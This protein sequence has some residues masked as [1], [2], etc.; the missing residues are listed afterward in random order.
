MNYIVTRLAH[1]IVAIAL[2]SIAACAS[3]TDL[4]A[5]GRISSQSDAASPSDAVATMDANPATLDANATADDA[6]TAFD[7]ATA[8]ADGRIVQ[9]DAPAMTADAQSAPID[10]S[11]AA[12]AN[13]MTS[14][15]SPTAS[16]ARVLTADANNAAHDAATTTSDAAIV[17]IDARVDH[18][19]VA[20]A[21]QV[22]LDEDTTTDVTVSATDVDGDSLIYAII[23]EPAH[24]SLSGILP[25]LTYTPASNYRGADSFTFKANDG[26]L[27][28]N[29]ATVSITVNPVNHA[30]VA[31]VQSVTTNENTAT[32]VTLS[33]TDVDGDSLTYAVVGSPSHG[34]LSGSAPNLTYTPTSNYHGADSFTFKANDGSLDSNTATV[35]ITVN[36]VDQAPVASTQSVNTEEN[37][38]ADVTMSA[39]DAD[40]DPLTYS[41]VSAP[42]HGELSGI[43]PDLTYTPNVN[44]FGSDSFTFKANDGTLDSN[45]ATVSISVGFVNHQPEASA[46]S[47][48]TNENTA[49]AVTLSATDVDGDTLTYAVVGSPSHGTLSGNA[50]NLTYTPTS[51]FH[52]SD[53]FTFKANDGIVDSNPA[54]VAITVTHVNQAP[55]AT[56]QSVTTNE[57]VAVAITL[58]A[59]DVDGDTLTYAVVG[60]PSHGTLSGTAPNLTYTPTANYQGADSFT[61][62]ASDG[63]LT[64][65]PATVSITDA[66]PFD[67]GDGTPGNP[68]L[69]ANSGELVN[70]TNP[71]FANSSFKVIADI[72]LT[73]VSMSPIDPFN[74][75]FDGNHHQISNWT[76][77][78]SNCVGLFGT[79]TGLVSD[80]ILVSPSVTGSNNA[81]VGA[82][83]GCNNG[84]VIRDQ[85]IGGQ[86]TADYMAGGLVGEEQQGGVI[87]GVANSSSSATVVAQ[88]AG[89]LVGY[90]SNEAIV[91]SYAAGEVSGT[92]LGGGLVG[93][94]SDSYPGSIVLRSYA[95]GIVDN[96]PDWTAGGLIGFSND[97]LVFDSFWNEDTSGQST[98]NGGVGLSAD[99]MNDPANF[100][101]WNFTSV[102]QSVS[103]Q[104]PTLRPTGNVAPMTEAFSFSVAGAT[105][106]PMTLP[107][108]DFNG[109]ALTYAIVTPP[110]RGTLSAL[111][112]NRVT[113]TADGWV[114]YTD[115]FTYQ[116]TDVHGLTSPITA[117]AITVQSACNSA[118]PGFSHG[119]DGS[120]STPYVVTNVSELQLVHTY[121]FCNY[122]LGND[123]DLTGISFS[124][125][126]SASAF[127]ATFDGNGHQILSWNYTSTDG[128]DTGF[129]ASLNGTVQNLTL[130][131]LNISGAGLVG[132][133]AAEASGTLTNDHTTGTVTSTG[134]S[135]GGLVA[136]SYATV[137]SCSSAATVHGA[138][139]AG[140]L[141]GLQ[142]SYPV[143]TSFATGDVTSSGAEAGGLIGYNQFSGIQLSYATGSV[144]APN[145]NAGGLLG[146]DD[147]LVTGYSDI[148]DSYATGSISCSGSAGAFIG[149][150]E[151]EESS[152]LERVY[153]TGAILSAATS[154]VVGGLM[155]TEQDD[156]GPGTFTATDAFWDVD[157]TGV[158]TTANNDGVPEPDVA[159]TTQSTYTDFDFANVWVIQPSGYPTLR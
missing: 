17:L 29:T 46:Q 33:A 26:S 140:G 31:N 100:T 19:P 97:Q 7:A 129:F 41:V 55:V 62:K 87:D 106:F 83:V 39:T 101:N 6:R 37:V 126:G 65:N 44:Y 136:S 22:T 58:S 144:T 20:S 128:T 108:F 124:P 139:N 103:G 154:A 63:S 5:D 74:G 35:S 9:P 122:I 14:D 2:L 71:D 79:L 23:D 94:D 76:Y 50:P 152:T 110:S 143:F 104:E 21:Q 61:F 114:G 118:E 10:A 88:Y 141:I 123:I 131:N 135:A 48:T 134:N 12:D 102:W 69:I 1:G 151:V 53:S 95:S 25:D 28:S 117:V 34:T 80:I 93:Y 96:A 133:L 73:G 3:H 64:S 8:T 107:A 146:Y 120:S 77:S 70:A 92:I 142:S 149:F 18:A 156:N 52:G 85:V 130:V 59:T 159:M 24:G 113:F 99:Q 11:V 153:A 75:T 57:N 49:T 16:D 138:Q 147:F 54:T 13:P 66:G 84:L 43:P 81:Y 112:G 45:T 30:P 42:S 47:V 155:G 127:N 109:D 72:D 111:D 98:S 150:A 27:D 90:T 137:T 38:A 115:Q 86:V 4:L 78:G 116:V 157:T 148:S 125:I 82:L 68:F 119:G 132:G 51:N 91:D 121:M 89:G 105:P 158:G 40:G 15:G 32:A 60:S 67:S 36:F 145:G 56:A